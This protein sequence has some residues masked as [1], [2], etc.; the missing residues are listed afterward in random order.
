MLPDRGGNPLRGLAQ[1]GWRE[2]VQRRPHSALAC[3]PPAP[4][5][6]FPG[7]QTLSPLPWSGLQMVPSRTYGMVS[8]VGVGQASRSVGPTAQY[9]A[10]GTLRKH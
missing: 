5:V 8:L 1:G 3:R 4:E 7:T 9:A 10:A 6:G 2:D